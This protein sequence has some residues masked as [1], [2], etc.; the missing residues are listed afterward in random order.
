[1]TMESLISI[2]NNLD[3]LDNFRIGNG[4]ISAR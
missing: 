1:M 3:S 2:V 4:D